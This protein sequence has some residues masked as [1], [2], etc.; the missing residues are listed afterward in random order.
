MPRAEHKQEI[1]EAEGP[2]VEKQGLDKASQ[3][4]KMCQR[5]LAELSSAARHERLTCSL[6]DFSP[7][8]LRA[9]SLLTSCLDC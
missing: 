7:H 5:R 8:S 9:S 4:R 3:E 2:K 6:Y 1:E